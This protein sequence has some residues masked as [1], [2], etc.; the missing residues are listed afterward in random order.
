MS[1]CDYALS[2]RLGYVEHLNSLILANCD[3]K[4]NACSTVILILVAPFKVSNSTF[5]LIYW[6]NVRALLWRPDKNLRVVLGRTCQQMSLLIPFDAFNAGL[7]R[8]P[9]SNRLFWGIYRPEIYFRW[10]SSCQVL[11]ILPRYIDYLSRLIE[12]INWLFLDCI[13]VPDKHV[14]LVTSRGNKRVRFIPARENQWVLSL[15][16]A[17]KFALQ[18]PHS[19]D[20]VIGAS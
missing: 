5:V 19:S 18:V 13:G 17:L 9:N 20:I 6:E 10:T 8:L 2:G 14:C 12:L 16:K 3:D 4:S 11:V 1:E 7:V 15:E